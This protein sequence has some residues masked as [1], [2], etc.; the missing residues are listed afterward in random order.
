MRTLQTPP[1]AERVVEGEDYAVRVTLDPLDVLPDLLTALGSDPVLLARAS[2]YRVG[3]GGPAMRRRIL[4]EIASCHAVREALTVLVDPG[5]C[6]DLAQQL[7]D[8]STEPEKCLASDCA[9]YAIDG[10]GH[11][12]PHADAVPLRVVR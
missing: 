5:Q 9:A 10:G 12:G 11:C 2:Q 4:H 8:S 1:L 3:D 7:D 6:D